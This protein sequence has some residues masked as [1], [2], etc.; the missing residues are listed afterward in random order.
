MGVVVLDLVEL[1]R[2]ACELNFSLIDGLGEAELDLATP[3]VEWTVRELIQHQVESTTAFTAG[4]GGASWDVARVPLGADPLGVYQA[5]VSEAWATFDRA[6]MLE[7]EWEFPG[8]GRQSGRTLVAAHFVDNLIH[9]WD[10]A[11][12]LG[13]EYEFEEDL[14]DAALRITR[15]YPPGIASFAPP[16]DVPDT[17]ST[18]DRL[19]G[20]LGRSPRWPA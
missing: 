14:A 9:A 11:R 5:A 20:R 1:D 8:F 4:T 12:A 18:T 16:V 13:Q 17:A 10:L 19:V 7:G 3:C 6:G 15:R 2:R